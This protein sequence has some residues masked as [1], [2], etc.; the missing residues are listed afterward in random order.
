MKSGTGFA[1]RDVLQWS[2]ALPVGAAL[3]ARSAR[4]ASDSGVRGRQ[5]KKLTLKFGSS[6]ATHSDNAHTVFFDS[7]VDTLASKTGGD[8]GAV[9]YGDSQLGPEDKYPNQINAGTL[10]MMMT[11]S[12]WTPIVPEIGVLTMGFLF[13]GLDQTGKV[14]DGD[15]GTLLGG[16]FKKKTRAEILGWCYNFGGR[17]VMTKSAV[18]TLADFHGKKL[19]VLPS[20]TYVQTFRLLGADP[21]PMSFNEIY[22]SLQTGVV[23]GLEHDP[24][25]ILQFKFYEIAKNITLTQHIFD[26]SAPIISAAT[27]GRLSAAEQQAVRD[28]ATAAVQVQRAKAS[29]AAS[30]ALD[31][32]RQNGVKTIDIDRAKL[33]DAVKPLWKS[34]T[35]QHA[36]AKPVLQAILSETGKTL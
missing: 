13:D 17:N 31:T 33:A 35:D 11:V 7:F 18:T 16:L 27:M 36:E 28:A 30:Q 3:G 14:M 8:I 2:L 32:L 21:V 9:F 5:G 15:A 6:Q 24:P 23:D 25:T 12:D 34:F 1:R 29:A 19:R 26:P 4:A 20:P 10:D 22:I